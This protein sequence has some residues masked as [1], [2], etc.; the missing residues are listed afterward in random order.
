VEEVLARLLAGQQFLCLPTEWI[1]EKR[2]SEKM[3]G[4]KE[5][6]GNS[7]L[8]ITLDNALRAPR[9][10]GPCRCLYLQN[11]PVRN[12]PTSGRQDCSTFAA[13]D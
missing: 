2:S 6:H 7:I 11:N 5:D 10:G 3:T 4:Q 13:I 8:F 9:V 12:A 1:S